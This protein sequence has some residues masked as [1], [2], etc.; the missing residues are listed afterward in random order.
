[1]KSIKG[2]YSWI[3]NHSVQT[4]KS[5]LRFGNDIN[6]NTGGQTFPAPKGYIICFAGPRKAVASLPTKM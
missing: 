6:Y 5:G 2:N 4:G 1:M 3:I